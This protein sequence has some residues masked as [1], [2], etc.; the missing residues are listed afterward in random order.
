MIIWF[1]SSPKQFA[2]L[3]DFSPPF[4]NQPISILNNFL[5]NILCSWLLHDLEAS[6]SNFLYKYFIDKSQYIF[7]RCFDFDSRMHFFYGLIKKIMI[8]AIIQNL[9]SIVIIPKRLSIFFHLSINTFIIFINVIHLRQLFLGFVHKK[10]TVKL[11]YLICYQI[12]WSYL[13]SLV[14]FVFLHR[15]LGFES[16][17]NY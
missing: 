16:K 4:F 8:F 1:S 13:N 7:R 15:L 12:I 17:I 11:I 9:T 6:F 10:L 2:K 3:N 14:V 5:I